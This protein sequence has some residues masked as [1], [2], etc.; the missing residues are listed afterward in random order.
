MRKPSAWLIKA[1][2]LPSMSSKSLWTGFTPLSA[3]ALLISQ[4]QTER[5]RGGPK[6]SRV[7]CNSS[8]IQSHTNTCYTID[9]C[10][11]Y[12]QFLAEK[13]DLWTHKQFRWALWVPPLLLLQSRVN[14][15]LYSL[16]APREARLNVKHN[17]STANRQ[18]ESIWSHFTHGVRQL[19]VEEKEEGSG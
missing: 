3:E 11:I 9:S 6:T 13:S 19:A 18:R 14:H 17:S 15:I 1:I 7:W 10:S 2:V 12:T 8:N 16:Y 4:G 5:N